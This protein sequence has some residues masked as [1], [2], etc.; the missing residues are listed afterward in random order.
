MNKVCL[1]LLFSLVLTLSYDAYGQGAGVCPV[2]DD[3]TL[4]LGIEYRTHRRGPLKGQTAKVIS[5][6]GGAQDRGETLAQTAYREF[7]EETGHYTFGVGSPYNI[8]LK[9]ILQAEANGHYADHHH[10]ASG[11]TYR[12]YFVRVHGQKP[13][14]Q[15][16]AKNAALARKKLG[17]KAHVEKVEWLSVNA[18]DLK[19]APWRNATLP[20]IAAPV[21]GPF[22]AVLRQPSAQNFLQNVVPLP[23]P[24]APKPAPKATKKHVTKKPVAQKAHSVK[25]TVKAKAVKAKKMKAFRKKVVRAK[26]VR[27]KKRRTKVT[28]APKRMRHSK[29]GRR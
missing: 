9:H 29:R 22:N 21:F 23:K 13:S 3:G 16:F 10:V 19:N 7:I 25:K 18:Q 5:D 4:G 12:T 11:Q 15:T 26:T 2:Y 20:G 28:R 27:A 6:F 8:Q 1:G 17:H 24:V 14:P